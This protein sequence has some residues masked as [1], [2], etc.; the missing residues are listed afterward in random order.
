MSL[1]E[2]LDGLPSRPGVYLFRDDGG[3]I[4]YVGKARSLRDRAR[5]YFQPKQPLDPH[6]RSLVSEIVD[7]EV[8]VTD[9]EVEAL[10]LENNLIKR[11]RPPYNV[12]LR[13]DKNH[14]YL[15]LT[16][17]EEYPRLHVVRRVDAD[18]GAYG[19]PYIPAG[20]SR[21]TA[22][23]VHKAF[24]IRSCHEKLDGRRRRP[25]LQHQIGRCLAPCVET[26]CSRARYRRSCEEARLFLDGRADEVLASLR[27]RMSS[28]SADERFEDAAALRDQIRDLERLAAPQKITTIARRD[29]DVF[30]AHVEGARAALQVFV[31]RGGRVVER[32]AFLLDRLEEP[33]KALSAT[34]QQYYGSDKDVPREIL[35]QDD[36]PERGLI[37]SWLSQKRGARVS[38]RVPRRGEKL[39][40]LDLLARN[41]RLAFDLEWRRPRRQSEEIL[42]AL[43][44]LLGLED[45][46][47]R[48][49]CFDV[50]NTQGSD[51]VAAMI[52]F[53]NARPLK[54]AYRKYRVRGVTDKPDDVAA[55]REAVSRRYRRLLEEGRMLP[56]LVLV[57]GGRGQLGAALEALEQIG[58]GDRPAAGLAKRE[59]LIFVGRRAE[60]IVLPRHSPVLQLLQRMRDEAHRFAIRFHR[61][62]R[63]RSLLR[64]G[65]DEIPGVGPARRRRLLAHFGSLRRLKLASEA[66]LAGVVG[67][68]LA[69]RIRRHL[70]VKET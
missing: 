29:R 49:E 59:E 32:E 33:D 31:V 16:L 22:A 55:I 1:R 68:S 37:E 4:L 8:I 67:E 58:L 38:I 36:F 7:I 18:G 41:A 56:D 35:V 3:R 6:K 40:L 50:S 24:G 26:I 44:D 42:C 5:T 65:L 64:S 57:D 12:L 47:R 19:G 62:S 51:V 48:I 60:P 28:A 61:A 23:V 9:S 17:A 25:C 46:P 34:L 54:S 69:R 63:S 10:A 20:L 15:K 45:A 66:D 11:H 52:C 14:P 30:Y 2:K 53:E 70:A 39:R 27:A 13:D 21:R 43:R